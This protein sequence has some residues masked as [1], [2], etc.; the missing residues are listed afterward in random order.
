MA[1]DVGNRYEQARAL[2]GIGTCL[3]LSGGGD[4]ARVYWQD[5]LALHTELGTPD[6]A[7][8]A[9]RLREYSTSS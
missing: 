9:A 8:V 5:A 6:A 3:S 4:A 1:R 2:A 7:E